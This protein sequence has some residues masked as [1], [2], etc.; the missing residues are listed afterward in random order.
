[1]IVSVDGVNYFKDELEEAENRHAIEDFNVALR[2]MGSLRNGIKMVQLEIDEYH[3][4]PPSVSAIV[5]CFY[6]SGRTRYF[7]ILSAEA[8]RRCLLA[9]E[10]EDTDLLLPTLYPLILATRITPLSIRH[11]LL[12]WLN[13]E[14]HAATET[15]ANREVY[16]LYKYPDVKDT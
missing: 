11:C 15:G 9:A 13:N 2:N 16:E 14:A 8:V 7:S 4:E 10:T 3:N 5:Q 6:D 1:M 12:T